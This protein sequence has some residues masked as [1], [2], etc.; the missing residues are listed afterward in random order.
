MIAHNSTIHKMFF[1]F[2]QVY[3]TLL[4]ISYQHYEKLAGANLLT[5]EDRATIYYSAPYNI[6]DKKD[7]ITLIN[8]FVRLNNMES[9][10][11]FK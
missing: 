11:L 8:T 4:E 5:S 1:F 7:S 3:L 2:F 6:F 9:I 10:L